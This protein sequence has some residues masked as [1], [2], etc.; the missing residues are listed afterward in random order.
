LKNV[1]FEMFIYMLS[2]PTTFFLFLSPY[3][4]GNIKYITIHF[5][6]IPPSKME[7]KVV[8]FFESMYIYKKKICKNVRT[9]LLCVIKELT[10]N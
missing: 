7:F 9:N 10:N 5:V 6:C 3:E 8:L 1:S 2:V 4:Q